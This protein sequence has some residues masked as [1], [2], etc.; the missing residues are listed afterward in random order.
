MAGL[1]ALLPPGPVL[2]SQ[3]PL[4]LDISV[5]TGPIAVQLNITN[6][7]AQPGN[8]F[9]ST[10]HIHARDDTQTPDFNADLNATGQAADAD[11]LLGGFLTAALIVKQDE[12]AGMTF[13]QASADAQAKTG[14]TVTSFHDA[15]MAEYGLLLALIAVVCLARIVVIQP[16]LGNDACAIRAK[17][18]AGIAILEPQAPPDPCSTSTSPPNLTP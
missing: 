6:P 2:A 13:E 14:V 1:L 5:N 18:Q 15:T 4:G 11:T 3:T 12:L 10:L 17:L 9:R 8:V 7:V 16:G